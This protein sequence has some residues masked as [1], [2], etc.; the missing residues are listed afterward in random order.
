[1]KTKHINDQKI[2]LK[3]L[4][5]ARITPSTMHLVRGGDDDSHGK[6]TSVPTVEI[7]SQHTHCNE[8]DISCDT[9]H[10]R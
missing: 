3:K 9:F 8:S 1:M 5:V 10:I 4:I 2:N 7:E 6:Q